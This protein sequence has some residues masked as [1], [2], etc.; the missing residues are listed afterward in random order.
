MENVKKYAV[1][2]KD[3]VVWLCVKIWAALVWVKDTSV[4]VWAKMVLIYADLK[5]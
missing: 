5:K 1:M 2:A 4:K 3:A